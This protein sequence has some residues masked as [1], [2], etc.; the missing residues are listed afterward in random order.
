M[1]IQFQGRYTE[2]EIRRGFDL[3][4]GIRSRTSSL[5]LLGGLVL[6]TAAFV[7]LDLGDGELNI[8]LTL[9]LPIAILLIILLSFVLTKEHR[10]F[11]S[12]ANLAQSVPLST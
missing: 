2:Q 3:L 4:S 9:A 11:Y 5:V 1:E 7:V 8:R 10:T 12:G 6:L